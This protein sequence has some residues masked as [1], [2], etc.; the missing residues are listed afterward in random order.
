MLFGCLLVS[1][2]SQLKDHESAAVQQD[3][4][5]AFFY[6][7]SENFNFSVKFDDA[8]VWLFLP[9]KTVNIPHVESASG[10]L[11]SDG[12]LTFWNNGERSR[13]EVGQKIYQDCQ[14]NPRKSIWETA[15]LKGVDFRAVGH[16]PSW[17]LEIN[18]YA[19]IVFT[20]DVGRKKFV[21]ST[22]QASIDYRL[23]QT[24][25]KTRSI[26]HVLEILLQGK[27]CTDPISKEVFNITVFV[28]MDGLAYNGCGRF[29]H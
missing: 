2:C 8:G 25:Y 27:S 11:Y 24:R 7:C 1:S 6:E 23:K 4:S 9:D 18:E 17:I 29:L 14:Y 20:T 19:K 13:L 5:K 21:F 28:G 22:P 16:K 12:A 15:K 3:F 26:E 10:A